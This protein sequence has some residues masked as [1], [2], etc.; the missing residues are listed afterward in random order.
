[1]SALL[2]PCPF[3]GSEARWATSTEADDWEILCSNIQ[4]PVFFFGGDHT[5][6]ELANAWNTRT[7]QADKE[8]K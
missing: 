1:M 3:C 5:G 2:K 7:P 8:E 6:T 4:C